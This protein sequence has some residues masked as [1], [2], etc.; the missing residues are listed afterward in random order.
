MKKKKK[1]KYNFTHEPSFGNS[2]FFISY[3]SLGIIILVGLFNFM[4][5][6]NSQKRAVLSA[7]TQFVATIEKPEY[8][9]DSPKIIPPRPCESCDK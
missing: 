2:V 9:S 4:W 5:L 1:K 3:I 8:V 7:Q 6:V